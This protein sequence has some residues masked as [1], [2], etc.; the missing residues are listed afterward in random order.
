M[1]QQSSSDWWLFVGAFTLSAAVAIAYTGSAHA[2]A[3]VNH[4]VTSG[5]P[6]QTIIN[7]SVDPTGASIHYTLSPSGQLITDTVTSGN[8]KIG[9][10]MLAGGRL[11]YQVIST[12]VPPPSGLPAGTYNFAAGL[13][14]IDGGF[15]Y[16]CYPEPGVRTYQTNDGDGQRWKWNGST[17]E[18]VIGS[19][20]GCPGPGVFLTEAANATATRAAG[21]TYAIAVSGTGWTIKDSR[22]GHYLGANGTFGSTATVWTAK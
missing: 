15:G 10:P 22:T 18:N 13:T 14:S 16:W 4:S 9:T 2:Q 6:T 8:A 20:P 5:D 12:A 1:K 11:N 21:D 19:N 7:P 3:M 17:L